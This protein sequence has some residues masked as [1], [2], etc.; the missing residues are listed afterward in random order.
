MHEKVNGRNEGGRGI[1]TCE[2]N[3]IVSDRDEMS[4]FLQVRG[5]TK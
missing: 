4:L 3:I 5:R 1:E 2:N